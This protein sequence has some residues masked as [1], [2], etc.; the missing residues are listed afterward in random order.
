MKV[1]VLNSGSSSI[2]FKLVEMHGR[3]V[4]ASGYVERI[5]ETSGHAQIRSGAYASSLEDPVADHA[6]A[7]KIIETLLRASGTVGNF[8]ELGGIGHRVVHGGESFS[9]PVLIDAAVMAEIGRLSCFAPL[10]NPAN[11][12][13]IRVALELAPH[14]PQVAVFDTAFHHTLPPRAYLYALPR[15]LY[16]R[17]GIRR[18]G[19]HGTSHH[20][21][22]LQAAHMMGQPLHKF[23][24]I[25][26]HLGNGSSVTA[27]EGGRSVD[28]SMGMTP[29]EGLVMGTR[30]GDIDAEILLF[31]H[32]E[33][34]MQAAD[35]DRIVNK[36]SGLKG[37]CGTNDMREIIGRMEAGDADATQAFEVFVYRIRK[38][39]GAYA[40][41]LGRVDALVFT[42]GIGEHASAVREA[43]C[44]GMD[45]M[46]GIALDPLRNA[47]ASDEARALHKEGAEV[48]IFVVPTDEEL[49]IAIQTQRTVIRSKE[50]L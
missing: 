4:L 29:L 21:V 49:K 50:P 8:D 18:Y 41:V 26:L 13:G 38:Y 3:T 33:K 43:V 25:T 14:V 20:Y 44:A 47:E 16:E 6:A 24:M 1:L 15:E 5:G 31:L 36:Q 7:L 42:G 9:E 40:A 28:T 48:G 19:F 12:Q 2:K 17:E 11:L 27:I 45:R 23:N 10:H 30:S 32:R 39:I 37:L 22:A 34:G 35:L 46:F